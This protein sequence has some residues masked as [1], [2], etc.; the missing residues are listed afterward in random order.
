[1]LIIRNMEMPENC[2]YCRFKYDRLC[3][4]ARQS[5]DC[6]HAFVGGRLEDCPLENASTVEVIPLDWLTEQE[7]SADEELSIAA[8]MV[9]KAWLTAKGKGGD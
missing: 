2:H 8:N 4:A 6:S 5:F 9:I 1:M 7:Y 3:F